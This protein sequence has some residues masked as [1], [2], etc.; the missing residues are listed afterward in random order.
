MPGS[1][2]SCDGHEVPQRKRAQLNEAGVLD[3]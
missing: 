1:E 3:P 2:V